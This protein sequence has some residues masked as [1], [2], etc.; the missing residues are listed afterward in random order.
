MSLLKL[1][2]EAD[3]VGPHDRQAPGHHLIHARGLQKL[4]QDGS[5]LCRERVVREVE[6]D[7]ARVF[8]GLVVADVGEVEIPRHEAEAVLAGV[9]GDFYV[10][11]VAQADVAN[12]GRLVAG[13]GDRFGG[14][15]GHVCVDQD[16]HESHRR[17][18]AGGQREVPFLVHESGGV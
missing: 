15:S 1:W 17:S 12:V 14:A 5:D 3:A 4:A 7:Q 13:V 6:D 16:L 10:R 11:R 18:G 9:S 2:A 8:G